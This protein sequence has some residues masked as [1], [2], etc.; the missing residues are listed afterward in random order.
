[1]VVLLPSRVRRQDDGCVSRRRDCL[2]ALGALASFGQTRRPVAVSSGADRCLRGDLFDEQDQHW[3]PPFSPGLSIPFCSRGFA[4]RSVASYLEVAI[5]G[6]N[7]DRCVVRRDGT[8]SSAGVSRLCFLLQSASRRS[9]A[10]AFAFR[11]ERRVG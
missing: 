9:A 7:T 5:S 2:V 1:M 8:G 3:H 11:F 10:L 6:R 4:P